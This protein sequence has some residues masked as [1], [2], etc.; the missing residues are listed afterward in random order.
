MRNSWIY[1]LLMGLAVNTATQAFEFENSKIR[2]YLDAQYIWSDQAD[3]STFL[4][5]EGALI[6]KR[7]VVRGKIFIDLP[8]IGGVEKDAISGNFE[9]ELIFGDQQAQAYVAWSFDSGLVLKAGQ[10]DRYMGF[11]KNDS[12]DQFFADRPFWLQ[13]VAMFYPLTHTGFSVEYAISPSIF[14]NTYIA[15]HRGLGRMEDGEGNPDFGFQFLIKGKKVEVAVN[16]LFFKIKNSEELG[17]SYDFVVNSQF[18]WLNVGLEFLI[19]EDG[20]VGELSQLASLIH[21]KAKLSDKAEFGIRAE[22]GN[23]LDNVE[24]KRVWALLAGPR[25]HLDEELWFKANYRYVVTKAASGVESEDDHGAMFSMMYS[26]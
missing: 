17:N 13:D 2:A 12:P 21:F 10:F 6:I 7:E 20:L 16:A 3:G 4:L 14:I 26:F 5:K 18:G 25:F 22:Y 19:F 24:G 1:T 11:V 8:I 23:D 9:N 15:N